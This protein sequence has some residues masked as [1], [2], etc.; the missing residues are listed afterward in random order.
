MRVVVSAQYLSVPKECACCAEPGEHSYAATA[1]RVTGK[2]VVRTHSKSWEFRICSRCLEHVKTWE[3]ASTYRNVS[4]TIGLVVAAAVGMEAESATAGISL[5]VAALVLGAFVF[6]KR[7]GAA[8][9]MCG[10]A[11]AS[12]ESPVVFLG[13]FGSAKAFDFTNPR[14]A[15]RFG[16]ANEAKLLEVPP[17]LEAAIRAADRPST[18][19]SEPAFVARTVVARQQDPAAPKR[20]LGAAHEAWVEKLESA[21]S[22]SARGKVLAA[23]RRELESNARTLVQAA[24]ARIVATETLEKVNSLRQGAAKRR[25]LTKAIATI[26]AA[27]ISE[28]VH[29]RTLRAT[30]ESL[31]PAS[32]K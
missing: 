20:P 12:V 7:R 17:D 27:G 3:S 23:A 1:T 26:E 13:W 6:A 22:A 30:L 19:A 10:E 2:R 25:R 21:R 14:I 8:R 31:K 18:I 24:F 28:D 4:G 15:G 29:L 9:S 5:A 16:L 11:C 32:T